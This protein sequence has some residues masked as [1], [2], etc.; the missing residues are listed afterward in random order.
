MATLRWNHSRLLGGWALPGP[1][2]GGLTAPPNLPADFGQVLLTRP[3]NLPIFNCKKLTCWSLSHENFYRSALFVHPV[4]NSKQRMTLSTGYRLSKA[5]SVFA[6]TGLDSVRKFHVH[7]LRHYISPTW[8]AALTAI[9]QSFWQFCSSCNQTQQ[10]LLLPVG[11]R[12]DE[13]YRDDDVAEPCS[14]VCPIRGRHTRIHTLLASHHGV[15][16]EVLWW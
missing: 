2:G 14:Y 3:V 8:W 1:M 6:T 11:C 16:D 9:F 4:A 10:R 7:H 13:T 15:S 5:K 12:S